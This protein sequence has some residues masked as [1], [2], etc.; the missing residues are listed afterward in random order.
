M[1]SLID[2][3]IMKIILYIA[4]GIGIL[5]VIAWVNTIVSSYEASAMHNTYSVL[6]TRLMTYVNVYTDATMDTFHEFPNSMKPDDV[7]MSTTAIIKKCFN[8]KDLKFLYHT[9][10]NF[11]NYLSQLVVTRMR[12]IVPIPASKLHKK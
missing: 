7:L 3:G 1:K 12:K 9:N 11:D 4:I 8:E 2:G 5:I 6:N 10:P